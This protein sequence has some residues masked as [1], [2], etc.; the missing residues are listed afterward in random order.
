MFQ[1]FDVVEIVR[2]TKMGPAILK[3]LE[4]E[5]FVYGPDKLALTNALTAYLEKFPP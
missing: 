5:G 2:V 4:T 3:K 1:R